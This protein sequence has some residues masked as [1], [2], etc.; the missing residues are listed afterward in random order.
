M[1]PYLSPPLSF[2]TLFHF[3]FSPF[4][5]FPIALLPQLKL[6]MF[7]KE[8]FNAL[9]PIWLNNSFQSWMSISIIWKI[10][11]NTNVI[12]IQMDLLFQ[13]LWFYRRTR[14]RSM[15]LL[16]QE[17]HI[18]D[19]TSS[20]NPFKSKNLK[21]NNLFNRNVLSIL[22]FPYFLSWAIF[23]IIKCT[24]IALDDLSNLNHFQPT[25]SQLSKFLLLFFLTDRLSPLWMGTFVSPLYPGH[26]P[27]CTAHSMSLVHLTKW[28]IVSTVLVFRKHQ[29]SPTVNISDW[30]QP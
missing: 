27:Q 7:C 25:L 26:I 1:H 29:I 17:R 28:W 22:C 13:H 14:V 15:D 3:S 24:S 9:S 18:Q 5:S 23:L 12:F 19:G 6:E 2:L 16:M 10:F 4:V 11:K 8:S 21:I 20:S 30:P